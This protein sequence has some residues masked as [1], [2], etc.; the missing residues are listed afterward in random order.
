MSADSDH[1]APGAAAAFDFD[2][3]TVERFRSAFPRARWDDEHKAWWVPGKTAGRR[4]ARWK[5]IEASRADVHADA[6]GRDAFSFEPI[7]SPYLAAGLELIVRTP[8]SKTVVEALR[9]VPFARWDAEDRVWRVPYRAYDE[10]RRRWPAIEAA[11]RRNE[12][13]ERR[14][15]H[16]AAKGSEAFAA[17]RERAAE[18]RR[19]RYPVPADRL[20]PFQCPV[21]TSVYGVIT[22][23]GTGGELATGEMVRELY[24][25]VA[26]PDL[27]WASWRS[28]SLE[29]LVKT[30]P[31]R[32]EPTAEER[33]RGWWQ[34]TK[35]ELVAARKIARSLE[36][37][38]RR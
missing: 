28:P 4:I 25:D 27:I 37:R 16:E 20:P 7:D 1:P 26:E 5:D 38:R 19:H 29:E 33:A 10:L 21:S 3:V 17:S 15:R 11:A 31:A 14:R 8:Y 6:K 12:P 34:P 9:Q 2:R 18:R 22:F 32:R 23:T 35:A 30:W 13:E 36:R 24:P